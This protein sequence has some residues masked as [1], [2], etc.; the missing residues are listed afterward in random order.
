MMI[1]LNLAIKKGKVS[2][3]TACQFA[4]VLA[5]FAPHLAE[6]LWQIHGNQKTLAYEPWPVYNEEYLKEDNFEYPVSF[7]GKMRFSILLPVSMTKEEISQAVLADERAKKWLGGSS[8]S[9]IIVVPNRIVNI[10]I[11]N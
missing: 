1:F 9:N 11:K 2:H 8:P 4:K 10:V 6:E 7:N 5:P 3:E